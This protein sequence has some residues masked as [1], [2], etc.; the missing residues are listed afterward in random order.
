MVQNKICQTSE[1]TARRL[2]KSKLPQNDLQ[3]HVADASMEA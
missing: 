1:K 3:N 2:E